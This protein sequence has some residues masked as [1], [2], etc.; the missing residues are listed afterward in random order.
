MDAT[1]LRGIT[2][3]LVMIAFLGVCYWAYS[4]KQKKRFDEAAQLPFA[5]DD[6]ND[7]NN[8]S[9]QEKSNHE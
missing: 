8:D 9:D 4:S 7:I 1:D 2:T 3:L 6:K 5:D